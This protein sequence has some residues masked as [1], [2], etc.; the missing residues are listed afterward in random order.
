[1]AIKVE[2]PAEFNFE[3]SDQEIIRNGNIFN[4]GFVRAL[5][6]GNIKISGNMRSQGGENKKFIT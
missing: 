1:M 2:Y 5:E 4:L 3:N 6:Q